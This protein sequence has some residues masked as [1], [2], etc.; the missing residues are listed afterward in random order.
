MSSED[1]LT[2]LEIRVAEQDRVIEDLS[3]VVSEQW[4]TIDHLTKQVAMLT[5]RFLLL[6]SQTAPEI[7]IT[8]PPHW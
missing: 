7:P 1:R 4:K 6:E 8:K 3:S 5:D 2:E